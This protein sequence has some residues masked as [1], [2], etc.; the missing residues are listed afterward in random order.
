[1]S[2]LLVI[3]ISFYQKAKVYKPTKQLNGISI[4]GTVQFAAE[5]YQEL[6]GDASLRASSFQ[7]YG[8]FPALRVHALFKI[9]TKLLFRIELPW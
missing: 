9:S 4:L 5:P 1:M 2:K 8:Q 3:E 6:S 7:L